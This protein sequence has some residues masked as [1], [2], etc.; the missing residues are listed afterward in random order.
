MRTE[1]AF[2]G[3]VDVGGGVV[4]VT[5]VSVTGGVSPIVVVGGSGDAGCPVTFFPSA[6]L[7]GSGDAFGMPCAVGVPVELV[8][9]R[10]IAGGW[11]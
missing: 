8:T 10:V 9:G 2:Y 6:P 7:L 1:R 5:R 11:F 4:C 3:R